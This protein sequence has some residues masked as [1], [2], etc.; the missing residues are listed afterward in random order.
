MNLMEKKAYIPPKLLFNG[1]LQTV[2]PTLFREIKLL[3]PYIH[4]R[5]MTQDQDFLDLF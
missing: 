2:Y 3:T 4:E 5:I 1:H